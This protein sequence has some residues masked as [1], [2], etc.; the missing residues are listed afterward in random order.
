[1]THSIY[2]SKYWFVHY[3]Q[4]SPHF[5]I[6]CQV[7]LPSEIGVSTITPWL[8]PFPWPWLMLCHCKC[9]EYFSTRFQ[10]SYIS[11]MNCK[12]M[13]IME[14][15]DLSTNQLNGEIPI[16]GSFQAFTQLRLVHVVLFLVRRNISNFYL[17]LLYTW[18]FW[19]KSWLTQTKHYTCTNF[20]NNTT[21]FRFV[22]V[23]F[24][25]NLDCWKI[26]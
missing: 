8:E 6:I 1:M 3:T 16:N 26:Y 2:D 14:S 23:L 24:D 21:P 7:I 4:I 5:A 20:T 12:L 22:D 10:W 18:Q 13:V 9:C 11:I 19:R 17:S 25:N 15:S